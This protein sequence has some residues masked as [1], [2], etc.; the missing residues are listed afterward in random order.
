MN[1]FGDINKQIMYRIKR[2]SSL[3]NIYIYIYPGDPMAPLF[4]LHLII[5]YNALREKHN[6]K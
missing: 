1:H 5:T 6:I 4:S 2:Q 3:I